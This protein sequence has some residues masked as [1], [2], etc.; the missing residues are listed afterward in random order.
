MAW[1]KCHSTPFDY[2]IL[3]LVS[4]KPKKIYEIR[5]K[6]RDGRVA[7]H[8]VMLICSDYL[9]CHART[10]QLRIYRYLVKYIHTGILLYRQKIMGR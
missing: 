1:E 8:H 4:D 3:I 9:Q 10:H 6:P 2:L 5:E 7:S